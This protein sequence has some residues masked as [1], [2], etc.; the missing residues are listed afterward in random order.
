MLED[1]FVDLDDDALFCGQ[2]LSPDNSFAKTIYQSQPL[3]IQYVF[4]DQMA[5]RHSKLN[6]SRNFP[7]ETA[8][9]PP[10]EPIKR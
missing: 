10:L 5:R 6:V 4:T 3:T 9:T 7:I 1:N 8:T 2:P